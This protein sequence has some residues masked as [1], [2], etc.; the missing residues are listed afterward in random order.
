MAAFRQ[1]STHGQK[2]DPESLYNLK[3]CTH[4]WSTNI[5]FRPPP[6]TVD[7]LVR[8]GLN[9]HP[10]GELRGVGPRTRFFVTDRNVTT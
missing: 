4:I 10:M 6:L 8:I 5:N 9:F 2:F 3:L 7:F 1:L